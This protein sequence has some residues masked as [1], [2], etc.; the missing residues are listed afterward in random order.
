MVRRTKEAFLWIIKIL[1]KHKVRFEIGGGLAAKV[2]GSKRKLADIDIDLNQKNYQKIMKEIR[3]YLVFG[4]RVYKDKNWKLELVTLRYK[5]QY[6]DLGGIVH[7]KIFNSKK[8][9]WII[10]RSHLSHARLKKIYGIN[11]PVED[12]MELIS[13][14]KILRRKVDLEDVKQLE[15]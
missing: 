8:K 5:G 11:V 15:D 1:K 6:I 10:L 3:P 9:K 13:Y 2:Y 4:P 14:K 7:A 12:E